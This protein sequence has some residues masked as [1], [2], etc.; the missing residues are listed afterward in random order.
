MKYKCPKCNIDSHSTKAHF[1]T[2]TVMMGMGS[3]F[4][5]LQFS[6]Q[7]QFRDVSSAKTGTVYNRAGSGF[8]NS[9][10]RHPFNTW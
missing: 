7:L 4:H 9:T 5:N 1:P 8:G 6:K 2:K 3:N 10:R